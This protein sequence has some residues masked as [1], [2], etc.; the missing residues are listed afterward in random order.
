MSHS[1][2]EKY[3]AACR[4]IEQLRR[5][6]QLRD[7]MIAA[8]EPVLAALKLTRQEMRF[9]WSLATSENGFRSYAD[10]AIACRARVA[11]TSEKLGSVA[12]SLRRKLEPFGI[13]IATHRMRGYYLPKSSVDIIQTMIAARASI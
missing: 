12:A 6:I 13:S 5:E 2:E 1:F 10:L 4:L 9:L 8:M 7:D 11:L 3:L